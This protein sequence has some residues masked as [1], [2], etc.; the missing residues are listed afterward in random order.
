VSKKIT[1]KELEQRV[2]ELEA[3]TNSYRGKEKKLKESDE[4]WRAFMDYSPAFMYI[5][6]R[7]LK[8]LY[9]NGALLKYFNITLDEFIGTTSYDYLPE[10]AAKTIEDY[11]REVIEK[12]CPIETDDVSITLSDRVIH[13]KEIKFPI[14][15]YGGGIGVGGI[16]M[17]ITALKEKEKS[18]QKAYDEIKILKDSLERENEV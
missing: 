10:Y 5:K 2:R 3:V 16:V 7:S 18:L 13:I 11:D 6:D 9:A 4:R 17:D 15:L 12:G 1:Y 14:A 8:H